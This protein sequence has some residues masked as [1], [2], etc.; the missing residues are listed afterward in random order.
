[1]DSQLRHLNRSDHL[2]AYERKDPGTKVVGAEALGQGGSWGKEGQ[3]LPFVSCPAIN[4]LTRDTERPS[5]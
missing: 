3:V 1:V 2:T 4:R 5:A